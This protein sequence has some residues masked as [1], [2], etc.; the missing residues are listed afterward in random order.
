[1]GQSS[2]SPL[3]CAEIP[4]GCSAT[5]PCEDIMLIR[6]RWD[7]NRGLLLSLTCG[8]DNIIGL[9]CVYSGAI[10]HATQKPGRVFKRYSPNGCLEWGSSF[11]VWTLRP[12]RSEC[13]T[14]YTTRPPDWALCVLRLKELV[15]VEGRATTSAVLA[16][17]RHRHVKGLFLSFSAAV[18]A[19]AGVRAVS[20]YSGKFRQINNSY[21]IVILSA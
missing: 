3:F 12:K 4:V 10:R 7:V 8:R 17:S 13:L 1:M 21:L 14:F 20:D 19:I 2:A 16:D 15:T 18:V 6:F 9:F 11:V 5:P